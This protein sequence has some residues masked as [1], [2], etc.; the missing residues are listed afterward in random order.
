M[1]WRVLPNPIHFGGYSEL[2]E[3]EIRSS[4]C[5]AERK[6]EEGDSRSMGKSEQ[7]H[8]GAVPLQGAA[9]YSEEPK[10]EQPGSDSQ[11]M[12]ATHLPPQMADPSCSMGRQESIWRENPH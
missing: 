1:P 6:Q 12:R 4:K 3:C 11:G 2:E 10:A 8:V 9:G 7:G 5:K